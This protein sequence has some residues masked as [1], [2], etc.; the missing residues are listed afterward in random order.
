MKQFL[1]LIALMISLSATSQKDMVSEKLEEYNF[2][3]ES[4]SSGLKDADA[5]HYFDA[6]LT[7]DDG[8]KI[9]VE[10]A[11]FDPTKNI[12]ERWILVSVDGNAPSNKDLKNFD[13]A[14]NTKQD[15]INAEVDD[16]SWKVEKDDDEYLVISFK[17]IRES[18]PR[19]YDFLADCKGLAY[20]NKSKLSLEKAEFVSEKPL[21]IK[22]FNVLKL[23]MI[24]N[25]TYDSE[26]DSYLIESEEID[27]DVKLLGQQISVKESYE[28]SNY[29]K[30]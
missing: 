2:S 14:H 7:T 5:E 16:S 13:K 18:L 24:V 10:E 27:M 15:D 23:D 12:G 1:F 29:K 9:K 17:Y 21:K 30:K 19:K 25:F 8:T 4:L 11:K 22:V 3:S 28:F 26:L 20:F 6:K